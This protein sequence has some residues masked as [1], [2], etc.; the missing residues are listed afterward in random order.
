MRHKCITHDPNGYFPSITNEYMQ[1]NPTG[2][3]PNSNSLS[4]TS[5]C[6]SHIP[7]PD[8]KGGVT[9]EKTGV[10]TMV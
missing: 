6:H 4:H 1:V 8:V 5:K 3:I 7:S 10:E 2:C 9:D